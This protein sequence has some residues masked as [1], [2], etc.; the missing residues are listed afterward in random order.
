MWPFPTRTGPGD[1][2]D[3]LP[4]ALHA[5]ICA[6]RDGLKS[7]CAARPIKKLFGANGHRFHLEPRLSEEDVA[8]FEAE[9]GIQ[10]PAEYRAFLTCV[11]N[12]DVGPYYG[13]FRL[14]EMDDGNSFRR[15]EECDGFVGTLAEP[16]PLTEAWNDIEGRPQFDEARGSDQDY[17]D[18]Y[19]R[20]L[21]A[22][23]SEKYWNPRLVN[24]AIPICHLGCALR[25][26]LVVTGPE[27]GN[28]WRDERADEKGLWPLHTQSLP[29][30]SFL[31]WYRRWLDEAL[32]ALAT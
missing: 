25:E 9:H 17:M 23:E 16:F 2:A 3:L 27:A 15:W 6:T 24:G 8:R 1:P 5:E 19:E 30:V 18:E 31:R 22:W 28:V 4:P 21:D 7:L 13:V 20:R 12:G 11:G 26:W 32:A 10:L 29:R 14:G